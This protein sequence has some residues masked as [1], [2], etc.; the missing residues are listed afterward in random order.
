MELSALINSTLDPVEIRT[1]AVEAAAGLLDAERGSLLLMDPETSS[2]CFEVAMGDTE[3]ALKRVRL[4]RGQ[5]I[6][7]WVA[8]HRQS[9]II[10]DVHDD[11]RFYGHPESATR[12]ITRDM[13][14]VPVVSRDRVIGV[15]QAMNKRSGHF[16]IEDQDLLE[17]LAHQVAVAI[18][19]ANLYRELKEAFHETAA[20][21]ADTIEKR[22]P[23]TGGHTQRVTRYSVAI[24]QALELP[25][26][27][28]E[29]VRLAAILHDIGKISVPDRVLN[30]QD[31]LTED[32]FDTMRRHTETAGEILAKVHLLTPIIPG[33][34]GHHERLDGTGYPDGLAGDDIPLCARIIA[35][36]DAFDAMTSDRPY[37]AALPLDSAVDELLACAGTQFDPAA[38]TA[39]ITTLHRTA[40]AEDSGTC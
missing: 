3:G 8:E 22:D 2:L 14:C 10:H 35:V 29:T 12:F 36:A 26:D 23:Y 31:A 16:D 17:S 39:F 37:R 6:A 5:G 21:L 40:D 34:R 32:E 13:V 33:V 38:T 27:D 9:A 20:A 18:D 25:E 30:K 11:P 15:L 28:V 19:N 1:R 4:K 7:G 24:A